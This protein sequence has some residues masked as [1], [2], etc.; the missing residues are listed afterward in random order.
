[1]GDHISDFIKIL[2]EE[3]DSRFPDTERI[4]IS[5]GDHYEDLVMELREGSKSLRYSPYEMYNRSDGN[6]VDSILELCD[7]WKKTIT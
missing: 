4:I 3:L 5:N 1:M 6:C 2:Y 7:K